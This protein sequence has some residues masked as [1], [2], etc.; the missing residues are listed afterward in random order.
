MKGDV[1][2]KNS[3]YANRKKWDIKVFFFKTE[4]EESSKYERWLCLSVT[5]KD[6]S[7]QLL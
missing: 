7:Q 2:S 4:F 1:P 6:Y 3:N 5:E